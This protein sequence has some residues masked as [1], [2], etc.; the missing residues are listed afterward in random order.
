MAIAHDHFRHAMVGY[1]KRHSGRAIALSDE[2][3]VVV[4]RQL[5]TWNKDPVSF[6]VRV[7][8]DRTARIPDI[9]IW[10]P[11]TTIVLDLVCPNCHLALRATRWKDGQSAHD[12]PRRLFSIQRH[13]ILISRVYRCSTDH[14]I[15]A[16]LF[17]FKSME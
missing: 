11:L 14:Q 2:C 13:A 12:Q 3:K 5:E 15:L 8:G 17:Y 10:D 16:H 7:Q 1:C 9:I 6:P 4:Q